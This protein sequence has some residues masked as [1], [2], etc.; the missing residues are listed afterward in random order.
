MTVLIDS[1]AWIEYYRGSGYGERA[2]EI[3]EGNEEA[4]I[5]AVNIAEIYRWLLRYYGE[6]EAEEERKSLKN[7]CIIVPVD[8]GI[9]VEAAK[10]RHKMGLGLGDSIVL[11]TARKVGAK[12][13]TG[14]RAFKEL[15]EVIY[16]GD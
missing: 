15:K 5:S 8:E 10:I 4:Y 7:R 12:V 9:A 16:L 6:I 14:D 1:W 11:A 13:V 2:R 3:I